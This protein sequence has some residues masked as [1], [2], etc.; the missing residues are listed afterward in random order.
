MAL[1]T[2]IKAEIKALES[3]A[4]DLAT[5]QAPVAL[6]V[7]TTLESGT[8]A[9]QASKI[10]SDTR[11][12]ALSSNEDLD[13]AAVLTSAL[14]ATLT[15]ATVK[16]IMIRAKATN[17]NNVVVGPAASNGFAGPFGD[18]S[19]R[20]AIKPGGMFLVTAPGTGWTVTAGTGDLLN[21][22]NSGAGTAVEYDVVIVGT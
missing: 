3:S 21:V 14:G 18:A 22:A 10:F 8:S 17:S 20:V 9:N 7:T 1:T 5:A 4:A 12:V 13:L 15:F 6:S 11:S 19:D 16:A 2:T